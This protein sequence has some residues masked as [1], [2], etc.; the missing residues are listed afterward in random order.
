MQSTIYLGYSLTVEA[1]TKC[2]LS[3]KPKFIILAD[4][5]YSQA[6]QTRWY[7]RWLCGLIRNV[8]YSI[9]SINGF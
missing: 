1:G 7:I 4:T 6:P 2:K 5:L 3:G 9:G 8:K